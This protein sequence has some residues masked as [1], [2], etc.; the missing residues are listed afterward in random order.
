ME[1]GRCKQNICKVF[2][3]S[4]EFRLVFSSRKRFVV[5]LVVL[6]CACGSLLASEKIARLQ[7]EQRN[8]WRGFEPQPF[9]F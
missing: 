9:W 5:V 3:V 7:E 6:L 1:L 8:I 2:P 4:V